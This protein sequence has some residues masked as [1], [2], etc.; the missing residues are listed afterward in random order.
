[1]ADE[2]LQS[3][4]AKKQAIEARK[5]VIKAPPPSGGV[6]GMRMRGQGEGRG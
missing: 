4:W 5:T 1:M 3:L 6:T 2:I